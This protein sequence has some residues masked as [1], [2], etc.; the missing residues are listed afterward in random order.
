MG[1]EEWGRDARE[2]VSEKKILFI[3]TTVRISDL[4]H[5]SSLFVHAHAYDLRTS[6]SSTLKDPR[7][8]ENILVGIPYIVH[9]LGAFTRFENLSALVWMLKLG[10]NSNVGLLVQFQWE[11]LALWNGHSI[12]QSLSALYIWIWKQI[13][14][15]NRCVINSLRCWVAKTCQEKRQVTDCHILYLFF[16]CNEPFFCIHINQI[17]FL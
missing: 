15:S 14:L 17:R 5:T 12:F 8:I 10:N 2:I 13:H 16:T 6:H 9:F 7:N 4:N 3:L 11:R 1:N